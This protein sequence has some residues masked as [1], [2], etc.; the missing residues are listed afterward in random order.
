MTQSSVGGTKHK[1]TKCI[2]IQWGRI[3][4]LRLTRS[5]FGKVIDAYDR[6]QKKGVPFPPSLFKSLK[7]EYKLD[8]KDSIMWGQMHESISFDAY[9][10]ET[11]N[12]VEKTGLHLFECGFLGSS[13]DGIVITRSGEKGDPRNKMPL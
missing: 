12:I 6:H 8:T 9:I 5:N 4:R 3:R 2:N 11:G 13:P 7:G 1:R 10:R